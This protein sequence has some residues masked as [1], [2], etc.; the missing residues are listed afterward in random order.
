MEIESQLTDPQA[1]VLVLM[2]MAHLDGV[3]D[4][5]RRPER[6]SED[7]DKYGL[8]YSSPIRIRRARV[9]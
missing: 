2:G 3:R 1:R 5:L 9:N 4:L 6:I 8:N 7:F